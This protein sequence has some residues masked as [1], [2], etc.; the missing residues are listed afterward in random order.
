MWRSG[1]P[2]GGEKLPERHTGGPRDPSPRP[3]TGPGPLWPCGAG[4]ARAR[5]HR[6]AWHEGRC[7]RAGRRARLGRESGVPL[8]LAGLLPPGQG[9]A[10]LAQERLLLLHLAGGRRGHGQGRARHCALGRLPGLHHRAR[11]LGRG[12]LRLRRPAPAPR[13]PQQG[14]PLSWTCQACPSVCPSI[15]PPI[16]HTT[17]PHTRRQPHCALCTQVLQARIGDP[18]RVGL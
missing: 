8:T 17:S 10:Q 9:P 16:A 11:C 5:G 6:P 4:S 7:A 2:P 15:G 12:P 1:L 3:R 18:Q 14:W 13:P